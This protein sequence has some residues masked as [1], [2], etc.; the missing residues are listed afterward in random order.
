MDI[1]KLVELVKPHV[2]MAELS[3]LLEAID[4]ACQ[5]VY[6]ERLRWLLKRNYA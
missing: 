4:I 2:T 1:E 3:S 6:D 5:E